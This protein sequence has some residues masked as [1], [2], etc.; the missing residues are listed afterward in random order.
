MIINSRKICR[1]F[2]IGEAGV[3]KIIAIGQIAHVQQGKT[4]QYVT[5]YEYEYINWSN[6]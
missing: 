4:L 5:Y 2:R 3:W 1:T 6:L